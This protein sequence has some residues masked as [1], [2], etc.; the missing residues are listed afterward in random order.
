MPNLTPSALDIM[1]TG[2][3]EVFKNKKNVIPQLRNTPVTAPLMLM[4]Q[5]VETERIE[6][7]AKNC[8]GL[9][10]LHLRADNQTESTIAATAIET[11]CDLPA[12]M[13][14]SSFADEYNLNGF[15]KE[16]ITISDQTCG[17]FFEFSQLV[18]EALGSKMT[19]M[20]Q[21]VN[22]Y[23]VDFLETNKSVPVAA[24]AT[25]GITIP[26]GDYTIAGN[27]YW[28]GDKVSELIALIKHLAYQHGIVDG[29][30]ISGNGLKIAEINSGFNRNNVG[31]NN[32][33]INVAFENIEI[34]FD[35]KYIDQILGSQALYIVDPTAYVFASVNDYPVVSVQTD[36]EYNTIKGSMPL[37]YLN[38][39]A[40]DNNAITTLMYADG[41]QMKPV[42]VDYL[43]QKKCD[44]ASSPKKKH[45]LNHTWELD[46]QFV[47]SAAPN[48][49]VNTGIIKV[50]RT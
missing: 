1:K 42:M 31:T 16:S 43:Y 34:F 29:F 13:G 10:V 21:G 6:D 23:V 47:L 9:R 19:N 33:G 49:G 12:G 26:A 50:V 2:L 40:E 3:Y 4:K 7:G 37:Q 17:N 24:Y 14:V 35:I 32:Y 46:L 36:D 39:Y 27:E 41:G 18:G 28:I 38:M 48:D 20:V 22:T 30:V 25:D 45:H 5:S 8:L 15:V 11:A 44:K